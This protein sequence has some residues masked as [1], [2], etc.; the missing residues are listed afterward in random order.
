VKVGFETWQT[1]GSL[2]RRVYSA[3]SVVLLLLPHYQKTKHALYTAMVTLRL[4]ATWPAKATEYL[5]MIL[6]NLL[7]SPRRSW[8]GKKVLTRFEHLLHPGQRR[9]V[10]VCFVWGPFQTQE[11]A[12]R[13]KCGRGC[14]K[15]AK[16]TGLAPIL[17][18]WQGLASLRNL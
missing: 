16:M 7:H 13:T 9:S 1:M 18:L 10:A 8:R 17:W 2:A 14:A 4:R 5:P 3:C 12:E 6:P 15:K 11:H